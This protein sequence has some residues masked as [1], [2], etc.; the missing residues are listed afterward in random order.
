MLVNGYE[1]GE[2][3]TREEF[4]TYFMVEAFIEREAVAN[5]LEGLEGDERLTQDEFEQL[6]HRWH[7]ADYGE[8]NSSF[9][10]YVYGEIIDERANVI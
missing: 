6:R 8:E 5:W 9:L 2:E 4:A 10:E 3:P 1:I 7:K